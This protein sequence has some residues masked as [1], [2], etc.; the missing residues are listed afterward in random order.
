MPRPRKHEYYPWSPCQSQ[1]DYQEWKECNGNICDFKFNI[2]CFG[3]NDCQQEEHNP[4]NSNTLNL[5]PATGK[6]VFDN[7]VYMLGLPAII[8]G[9]VFLGILFLVITIALLLCSFKKRSSKQRTMDE[10]YDFNPRYGDTYYD[11]MYRQ[12]QDPNKI[13]YSEL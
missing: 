3:L 2:T 6:N 1:F 9:G 4:K 8:T 11:Y 7:L 10:N 5:L 13:E 12:E